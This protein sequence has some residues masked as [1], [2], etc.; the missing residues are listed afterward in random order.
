[1]LR[2]YLILAWRHMMRHRAYTAVNVAGLSVGVAFCLLAWRFVAFELS[3]D[4]FHEKADRVFRVTSTFH[5]RGD[6]D[7]LQTGLSHDKVG[8]ALV[9]EIPQVVRTARFDLAPELLV[10][11]LDGSFEVTVAWA[12][13]QLFEIL[14]FPAVAGDPVR[15]AAGPGQT[16][17]SE[18]LARRMFGRSN[19]VSE[20]VT[21]RDRE[22]VVEM[23]VGAVIAIPAN[24]TF[25]FDVLRPFELA[26]ERGGACRHTFVE[27]V[28]P[29]AALQVQALLPT[30]TR[31]HFGDYDI[32][33]HLQPL[34][35]MHLT[36]RMRSTP[37][38]TS[39]VYCWVLAGVAGVVLSIAC[40]NFINLSTALAAGRFQEVGLR[41]T[42]GAARAQ[43]LR[44]FL[45]EAAVLTAI[46][47]GLGAVLAEILLPSLSTL[48]DRQ[49]E[50]GVASLWPPAIGLAILLASAT[51]AYPAWVLSRPQPVELFRGAVRLAG[52]IALRRVLVGVQLGLSVLLA[53][54]A[55]IASAQVDYLLTKDLGYDREQVVVLDS[56]SSWHRSYEQAVEFRQR[57]REVLAGYPDAIAVA[58][59][60]RPLAANYTGG[61]G[62]FITQGDTVRTVFAEV[63]YD[64]VSALGLRLVE[65]RDFTVALDGAREWPELAV[66]VNQSLV[67]ALGWESAVGKVL[68]ESNR[69]GV[70][71][72]V[73]VVEDFHVRSLH[74]EIHP[75]VMPLQTWGHFQHYYVRIAPHD[76]PRT[77]AR[78]EEAWQQVSPDLPFRYTFLDEM[79]ERAYRQEQR[80][81]RIV[82]WGAGLA[83]AIAAIGAMALASLTAARRTKEI[84]VRK[85]LGATAV[86]V[87]TLLTREFAWLGGTASVLAWVGVYAASQRWL[88]GFAY[89]VELGAGPFTLGSIAVVGAVLLVVGSRAAWAAA[90][91]PVD[92]LRYE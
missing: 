24:S 61:S 11:T 3:Y 74:Q 17:I 88:E 73:G 2:N 77:L 35:A 39:P 30:F 81:D 76:I 60:G 5:S 43:V 67:R 82:R 25:H 38:A 72:V 6:G 91:N 4:T 29:M 75:L 65:G 42:L 57:Y 47:M 64:I 51:G 36:D 34:T 1:M 70:K 21:L 9:T 40:V 48:M 18:S 41:K 32:V 8:P 55:L 22:N 90:A 66:I 83:V 23:Q 16:V 28:V 49:L 31:A 69:K 84:G 50:M 89:R 92:A 58:G 26:P 59:F 85:V 56:G 13:P 37:K 54:A 27:L 15:A 87:V 10:Q 63:D 20:T 7:V 78:L 53:V 68:P 12:E 44:Q 62:H 52:S 86:D 79:V 19:A 80:W 46:A 33:H 14:S 45:T 71:T